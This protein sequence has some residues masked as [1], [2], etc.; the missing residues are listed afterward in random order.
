MRKLVFLFS[1]LALFGCGKRSA[2]LPNIIIIFT[3]DQGYADLGCYGAKDF[4][5]PNI[6]RL[7]DEGMRFTSFYVSEAVCSASRSS[8]LTGCYAQRI[9]IRG[10]LSPFA[11]TGLNR[12]EETIASMLKKQ[13]YSTCMVGK[14]H[15]GNHPEFNPMNYGFD[16]YLGLPYSNDM[17][18]VGYD[19]KTIENSHKS[20]YPQLPLIEGDSVI[21]IFRNL[22]DQE[23]I[24]TI[25]TERAVNFIKKNAE[26]PFFLY[27]A[28][29]M[30]HV[31]LAVSDKFKGFS[32]QGLYGDVMSEIDWSVGEIL[33]TLEDNGLKDNT[34]I[35]YTSD[36]GPWLNFGNHGG[37]A[38]P[39]RE[40]KGN[41]WEGGVRV[42]C[43]MYFP[44]LITAGTQSDHMAS[45]I[46]ILPTI[47]SLTG[48]PLPEKE[49]DG[50]NIL[51]L[52]KGDRIANPRN[53][54][55]YYYVGG[56]NAVR[57]GDWKLVVPH[58]YRSYAGVEPGR[59]GFPGPYSRGEA[60]LE[61]YN[62]KEDIRESN[63]VAADFPEKV[64][65]LLALADSTR[66]ALGDLITG[67]RGNTNRSPGRIRMNDRITDHKAKGLKYK[68][69][70][71]PRRRYSGGGEYALT[72]GY[73]A[74]LE[75]TD[76]SWLGFHGDNL[77][78]VIDMGKIEVIDTIEIGFL[79]NQ[80]S[81]I[82]LPTMIEIYG[83]NDPVSFTLIDRKNF[84]KIS[85]DL[86]IAI[87]S[88][89]FH[90]SI[91]T[92][93]IKVIASNVRTC[94]DWHPGIGENAWLFVD[95]VIVK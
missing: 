88:Y 63:D 84:G 18:P 71:K 13:G 65:E 66:I 68:L 93:Y 86:K 49:I 22:K 80:A 1:F 90:G 48:A 19:G 28:H 9:G 82:F 47:A 57:R 50:V 46:D 54:F 40:G 64:K 60:G 29:S 10:A 81:W 3:D 32:E 95:E 23:K 69:R 15:L 70:Y 56:L 79:E 43:V 74:S 31:P 72:D 61:L 45:T 67:V 14:W 91:T 26:H 92:Q 58:N 53:E 30:V 42:P 36:N 33:K 25:Y 37:S 59:D 24:T 16:E 44:E 83:A 6:D 41:S 85:K 7:A 38:F 34:L 5:T 62:L 21:E 89:Q 55:I 76:E 75:F 77:E 39:L 20:I 73:L 51:S 87:E 27:L 17:W 94:P 8:L 12:D 52:L 11:M 4:E 35:I 2:E 78:I